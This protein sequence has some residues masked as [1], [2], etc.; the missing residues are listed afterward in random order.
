MKYYIDGTELK[1]L[2]N[3]LQK[4]DLYEYEGFNIENGKLIGN[5]IGLE[6]VVSIN[7]RDHIIISTNADIYIIRDCISMLKLRPFSYSIISDNISIGDLGN[8]VYPRQLNKKYLIKHLTKLGIMIEYL[9]NYYL[10]SDMSIADKIS[11]L[12]NYPELPFMNAVIIENDPPVKNPFKIVSLLFTQYKNIEFINI[13]NAYYHRDSI[14]NQFGS[15]DDIY[16]Y[17]IKYILDG[18]LIQNKSK[19]FSSLAMP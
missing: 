17:L 18:K 5:F 7:D 14:K 3:N 4:H 1:D 8:G 6:F 19:C 15:K 16:K 2:M 10:Y 9:S 12:R 11:Y 13:G